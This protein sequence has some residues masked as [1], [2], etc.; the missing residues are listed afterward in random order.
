MTEFEKLS[1]SNRYAT[2]STHIAL[3]NLLCVQF[4]L[5]SAAACV[6]KR[7]LRVEQP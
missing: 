1:H 6:S 7:V 4:Q 3:K 5:A 2:S